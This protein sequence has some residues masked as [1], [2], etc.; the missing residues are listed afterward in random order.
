MLYGFHDLFL[1]SSVRAGIEP[2]PV[3]WGH[4]DPWQ[5]KHDDVTTL[6]IRY[7][8][9]QAVCQHLPFQLFITRTNSGI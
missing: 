2:T 8:Q 1:V 6:P 3:G 4:V 9:T 7:V 5:E